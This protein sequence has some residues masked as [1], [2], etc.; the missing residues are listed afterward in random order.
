M[1]VDGASVADSFP[2]LRYHARRMDELL[3]A[4]A[5]RGTGIAACPQCRTKPL[6]FP[7]LHVWLDLCPQCY[8]VW[9]DGPEVAVVSA[10]E[11]DVDGLPDP[12]RARTTYRTTPA[13]QRRVE[14]VACHR[15]IHPARALLTADGA[16]CDDCVS[17]ERASEALQDPPALKR[18]RSA[19]RTLLTQLWRVVDAD[20]RRQYRWPR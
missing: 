11:D 5:R 19:L 6:E 12:A 1:W 15:E 17:T 3:D 18:A 16:V 4:G 20:G 10:A 2:A 13:T 14:C 8:G 9:L 7:F